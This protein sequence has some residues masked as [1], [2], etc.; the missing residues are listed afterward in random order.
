MDNSFQENR[1]EFVQF[2][3]QA[4]LLFLDLSGNQL[5]TIH[6][7]DACHSLMWLSLKRN[8]IGKVGKGLLIHFSIEKRRFGPLVTFKYL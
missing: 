6:G 4:G 3:N 8:R 1:I 2:S 7:L 5:R